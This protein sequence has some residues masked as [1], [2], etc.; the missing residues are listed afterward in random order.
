M[1]FIM[2]E[3]LMIIKDSA[4]GKYN[5]RNNDNLIISPEWFDEVEEFFYGF[6]RV[7]ISDR[8][9]NFLNCFGGLI[10][11][12]WFIVAT[13]FF[14]DGYAHVCLYNGKWNYLKS[15]GSLLCEDGFD[16]IETFCDGFGIVHNDKEEVNYV[17]KDGKLLSDIWFM[18]CS[19]FSFGCA[20]VILHN[21][22]ANFINENG[23]LISDIDFDAVNNFYPVIDYNVDKI[24]DVIARIYMTGKGYN[25]INKRGEILFDVWFDYVDSCN[26]QTELVTI[27]NEQYRVDINYNIK[28]AKLNE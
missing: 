19:S 18:H 16:Y 1:K 13:G 25:F 22:K 26:I 6:S 9:Y 5:F 28:H 21:N 15:D 10:S 24:V 12:E 2:Q 11:S 27:K 3:T 23:N 8:G 20:V 7:Y 4:S 17:N 14:S